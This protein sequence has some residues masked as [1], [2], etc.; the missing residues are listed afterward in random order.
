MSDAAG[1]S[2]HGVSTGRI[3]RRHRHM[4]HTIRRFIGITVVGLLT[5]TSLSVTAGSA[6]A[7]PQDVGGSVRDA[8]PDDAAGPQLTGPKSGRVAGFVAVPAG[9]G[10]TQAQQQPSPTECFWGWNWEAGGFYPEAWLRYAATFECG[11]LVI[12]DVSGVLQGSLHQNP[13][14]LQLHQGPDIG[15]L[16]FGGLSWLESSGG[17][18]TLTGPGSF[19]INSDS[20]VDLLPMST[21][22]GEVIWIWAYLPPGCSGVGT[23]RATCDLDAEPFNIT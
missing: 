4:T 1:T 2:R 23:P 15:F 22:T 5:A 12:P 6:A 14:G 10:S 8:T 3:M 13:G 20:I 9:S 16:F 19:Y 21:P 11:S 7:A 17:E 18:I